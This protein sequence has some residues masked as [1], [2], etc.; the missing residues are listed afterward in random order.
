MVGHWTDI[1]SFVT[2]VVRYNDLS[3]VSLISDEAS[4]AKISQSL[5]YEWDAGTWR[6]DDESAHR[7]DTVAAT[8]AIKPLEQGVFLSPTGEVYCLGSGDRHDEIITTKESSPKKRGL[9]RGIKGIGE[10][11]YAVGMNRQVYKRDKTGKWSCID[12]S[13]RPPKGSKEVFGFEAIDGFDENEIYTVGWQGEIWL[14]DGEKWAKKDSPTNFILVDAICAGDGNVYACGRIGTLL[15]GRKDKW[16]IIEQEDL[17]DDIWSL[18]WY[19]DSLYLATMDAVYRLVDDSLVPVDMGKDQAQTCFHLSAA[20]GVLWSI[21]P[22]D[23][24]AFDGKKW[25]RID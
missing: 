19:E 23:L 22:K 9:M 4:N 13:A 21:G 25:T 14:Y 5:I 2:G 1:F 16:E 3:Y 20:D 17:N 8:L 10:S 7:W 12:K 6:A 11:L 24:M 18:A 15:R